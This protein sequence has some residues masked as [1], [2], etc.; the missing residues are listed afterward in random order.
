MSLIRKYIEFKSLKLSY[1]DN[2]SDQKVILVTHANGFSGS[3]YSYLYRYFGDKYRWIFLD[4][5]GHSYS[6]PS[7]EFSDWNFFKDQIIEIIKKENLQN[8]IGV[9][10]SLGGASLAL[11]AKQEKQYISKLLLLDPTLLSITIN[12]LG[13][14]IGNYMAK[15]AIKRR[16]EFKT[17][18]Q[19]IKIFKR[20][21]PFSNF[22]ESVFKDY[23]ETCFKDLENGVQLSCPPEVESKIFSSNPIFF[24]I[25]YKNLQIKTR[26]IVPKKSTV[27]SVSAAKKLISG[28]SESSILILEN[29]NHFFPLEK[30]NIVIKELETIL[31]E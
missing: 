15:N 20:L 26:I 1:Q 30:P 6:D 8:I 5:I 27:C 25:N 10:H 16:R 18:E 23:I 19:V 28:N 21:P 24:P 4:F 29:E 17:K 3:C 7:Q 12:F 2:E 11:A 13:K 14:V 22:E 9:G 31:N